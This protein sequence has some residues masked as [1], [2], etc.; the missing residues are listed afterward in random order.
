MRNEGA[1]LLEDALYRRL[2]VPLYE[3]AACAAL[4]EPAAARMAELLGWDDARR[5][6]QVDAVRKRL[7][8]DLSFSEAEDE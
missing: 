1:A 3:P 7:A 5:S 2:R 8:A 4:I 6:Q